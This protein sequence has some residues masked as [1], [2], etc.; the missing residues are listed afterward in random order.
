MKLY[1][2]NDLKSTE[3]GCTEYAV[4]RL[5]GVDLLKQTGLDATVIGFENMPKIFPGLCKIYQGSTRCL[6]EGNLNGSILRIKPPGQKDLHSVIIISV[7]PEKFV[8]IIEDQASRRVVSL[9]NL[10]REWKKAGMNYMV[11]NEEKKK[12]C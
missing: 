5:T 12:A 11:C 4:K 1:N 2:A 3:Y 6:I 10:A 9:E 7:I 8:A